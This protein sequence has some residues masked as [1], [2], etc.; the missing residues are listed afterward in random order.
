M[1]EETKQTVAEPTA[2]ETST[3]NPSLDQ[4]VKNQGTEDKKTA[5]DSKTKD[6]NSL[7]QGFEEVV[8]KLEDLEE[9]TEYQD[10]EKKVLENLYNQTL[11]NI[12]AAGHT[13]RMKS[14]HCQLGA[15][16]AHA[17]S[18]NDADRCA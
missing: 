15:W 2:T 4:E 18:R 8:V 1:N 7:N 10:K 9:E 17:L 3:P 11:R 12:T 16:F 6:E 14:P 5:T 13:T